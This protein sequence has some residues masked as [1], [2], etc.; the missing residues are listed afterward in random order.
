MTA[1]VDIMTGP[2]AQK[3]RP[4][5]GS[6][7]AMWETVLPLGRWTAPDPARSGIAARSVSRRPMIDL[8]AFW[9][10]G[11]AAGIVAGLAALTLLRDSS[12]AFSHDISFTL[13]SFTGDHV[14]LVIGVLALLVAT[15]TAVRRARHWIMRR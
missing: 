12:P 15:V 4:Q 13:T 1:A 2:V 6:V 14:K 8:L 7:A 10:G 3:N 9:L 5:Q 11:M